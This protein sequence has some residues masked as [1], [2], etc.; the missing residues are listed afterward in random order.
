MI[1]KVSSSTAIADQ[2][3]EGAATQTEVEVQRS[4]PAGN[5]D[6]KVGELNAFGSLQKAALYARLG[7]M[8]APAENPAPAGTATPSGPAPPSPATTPDEALKQIEALPKPSYEGIPHNLPPEDR[9]AIYES[10]VEEYNRKRA[11]IADQAI[12]SSQPPRREDFKGLP[13]RL[14][15]LE[16]RDALANYHSQIAEL[17]KISREAK[18][19][20]LE[21][22][23]E[24][25]SLTPENQQLVRAQLAKNEGQPA[26]VDTLVN[27]VKT[28]GFTK[29]APDEQKK[30]LNYVGGTNNEISQPARQELNRLLNDPHVNKA[31]PETFRKFMRDQPGLTSVVSGTTEPG[32]FDARRRPYTISGPEEVKDFEFHSGK[33]DALKYE[34]EIDGRK[35]P[36][37]MP[38]NPD[39]NQT[40]QT[41]DEV[42]R[43]LA[44]LPQASRDRINSVQVNP[45]RNP[46]DAYWEKEYGIPGF[47][48]YMTA[49]ADGNVSIYPGRASQEVLDTSLIHETGHIISG[50]EL[51]GNFV[52]NIWKKLTGGTTWDDWEEAMKKDGFS[53]SQYARSSPGEDFSETLALY[54]KVKGTPEEAEIRALM[55]ERFKIIDKLLGN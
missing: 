16:Y 39:P 42:A 23:P 6:S 4:E 53:A 44:A 2:P 47:R 27:L 28:E 48:S 25:Q 30:L 55:P 37:Y 33:A 26:D 31:D 51:D 43:G 20:N 9:Q 5:T 8:N 3:A 18:Q 15:E 32:E 24:F 54:M 52:T 10:R 19:T 34:V 40:Y 13:P 41:I 35:I 12:N 36:V 11:A 17:K 1:D 22:T 46:D 7:A 50:Q 45:Q 14:A 38:K 49:G 29:L 21:M